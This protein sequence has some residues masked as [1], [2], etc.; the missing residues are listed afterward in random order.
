M[1]EGEELVGE[2][3]GA[4]RIE[5]QIGSGATGVVYRARPAGDGAPVALK[6][7][8]AN[9]GSITGLE[10]RFRREASVLGKLSH[11]NIVAITDFGRVEG[12]TFIAMELLEG[13]T[14]ED[15]LERAPIEPT[16]ALA[17]YEPVLEALADAHRHEVVHRD[18]KPANVFLLDD[19]TVKLLDFGL[20]KMLSIEETVEGETLTRKGRIVGTPAYMAPEQITGVFI[21][22]RADVYALGVMLYELLADRRPFLYERRSE[23]LRAHLLEPIPPITEVREGLWVHERLQALLDRALAKDAAERYPHAGAMLEALRALP[24]ACVRLDANARRGERQR[25]EPSSAVISDAEREAITESAGI[26]TSSGSASAAG[27]GHTDT[28]RTP[29]PRPEPDATARVPAQT[30]PEPTDR[31][32]TAALWL[33]ALALLGAAAG[34]WR[35][36][37][38]R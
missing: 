33:L 9:L 8:Y 25:T 28:V 30:A 16:D 20:A 13:E 3:L 22:V 12:R 36:L 2:T 17:L 34:V 32:P 24:E 10:R 5:A 35:V 31:I 21:D 23:L 38:G 18:L 1:A 27:A 15:S 14:L 37:V 26:S 6:V 7:L 11:P 29:E 19:G 4:Y